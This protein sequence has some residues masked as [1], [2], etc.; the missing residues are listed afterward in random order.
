MRRGHAAGAAPFRPEI[1]KDRDLAIAHNLVELR[2]ADFYGRCHRGQRRFAGA[3][4]PC[5][6]KVFAG[7][8]IRLS[9]GW[10]ISDDGHGEF[11]LLDAAWA[12]FWLASD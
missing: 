6:G 8:S 1:N 10:A 12:V 2:G 4:S 11:L 5:V 7:N 3:A 9:A